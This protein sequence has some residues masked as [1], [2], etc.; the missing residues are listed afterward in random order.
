MVLLKTI[1]FLW[2]GWCIFLKIIR[3]I[4]AILEIIKIKDKKVRQLYWAVQFNRK[5]RIDKLLQEGVD[6]NY[7]VPVIEKDPHEQQ[8]VTT[9]LAWLLVYHPHGSFLTKRMYTYLLEKGADPLIPTIKEMSH[10]SQRLTIA[11]YVSKLQ[12]TFY[13]RKMLEIAKPD[14]KKMN[15][16]ETG[17]IP[18]KET[19][20]AK[21]Y[22]NFK[23][24]LD[25]G[26]YS[27]SGS[28]WLDED[29]SHINPEKEYRDSTFLD[30]FIGMAIGLNGV[31]WWLQKGLD[32]K[33]EDRD[34]PGKPYLLYKFEDRGVDATR[35]VN[36]THGVDYVPKIVELLKE[37]EGIDVKLKTWNKNEKYITKNGELVLHVKTKSGEWKPYNKTWQ[38]FIN[39][40]WYYNRTLNIIK[41]TII[42]CRVV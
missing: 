37:K 40:Y 28:S 10:L 21:R 35:L 12:R 34:H 4:V 36:F 38:Y 5:K 8:L 22:K 7:K 27:K 33:D 6:I 29:G 26:A 2:L 18:L 17:S 23:I 16:V 11:Q 20:F 32:W 41:S 30:L 31:Y 13:L 19:L 39:K 24:F 3:K 42:G 15:M 25:Y 14:A 9:L 1:F